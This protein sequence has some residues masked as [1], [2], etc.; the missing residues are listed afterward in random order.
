VTENDRISGEQGSIKPEETLTD[1]VRSVAYNREDADSAPMRAAANGALVRW[2]KEMEASDI[3]ADQKVLQ[4]A[5]DQ[6][7][8]DSV[9]ELVEAMFD[10]GEPIMAAA[11][12]DLAELDPE[13]MAIED[14]AE[15]E[16]QE[17]GDNDG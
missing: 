2:L 16:L 5:L 11:R 7:G 1:I 13:D 3:E 6:H 8:F 17:P 10:A 14:Q 12:M 15:F 9:N 4:F